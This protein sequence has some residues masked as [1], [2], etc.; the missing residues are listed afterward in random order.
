LGKV[1]VQPEVLLVA[2]RTYFVGDLFAP[3]VG[4]DVKFHFPATLSRDMA[5]AAATVVLVLAVDDAAN[6][7]VPA[8]APV[9]FFAQ[10]PSR[11]SERSM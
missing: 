9:S 2:V 11:A 6:V 1:S 5:G 10:A 8:A 3:L 7:S 4:V